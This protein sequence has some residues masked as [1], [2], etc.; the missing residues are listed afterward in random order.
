MQTSEEDTHTH[1]FAS[2]AG[3]AVLCF[4]GGVGG[5]RPRT[6]PATSES[7]TWQGSCALLTAAPVHSCRWSR[8][9]RL[10]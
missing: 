10:Q 7:P 9:L 3:V 1:A 5:Q 8:A 2:F 6:S 4:E